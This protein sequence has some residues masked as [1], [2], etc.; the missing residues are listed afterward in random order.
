MLWMVDET[1]ESVTE[2]TVA[3]IVT[4]LAGA[5]HPVSVYVPADESVRA[6]VSHV[7]MFCDTTKSPERE[8]SNR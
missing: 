3:S 4:I 8:A 2:F 6:E 7:I 1:T 5:E